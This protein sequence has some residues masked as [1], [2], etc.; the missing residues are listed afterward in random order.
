MTLDKH[1]I[2]EKVK[3]IFSQF[4]KLFE[5]DSDFE[6]ADKIIEE[7]DCTDK[8]IEEM[9]AIVA[10]TVC[11]K[12]KLKNRADLVIRVQKAL[13]NFDPALDPE[14]IKQLMKGLT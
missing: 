4:L 10:I 1:E 8:T 6:K 7:F 12:N 13:D 11:V 14:Y 2:D 9:M 5:P 3:D